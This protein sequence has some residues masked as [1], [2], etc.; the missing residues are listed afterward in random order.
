MIVDAGGGTI[1]I[2]S[3]VFLSTSPVSVEEVTSADC[4]YPDFHSSG[5]H[6]SSLYCVGILQGST[7]VN[8]RAENFLRGS[9]VFSTRIIY[10]ADF[11]LPRAPPGVCV[12]Q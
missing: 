4:A 6:P 7:R 12:R 1:D 11:S 9:S 2:S 5:D 8:V 3:Y 10:C